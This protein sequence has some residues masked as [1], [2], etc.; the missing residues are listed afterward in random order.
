MLV[1]VQEQW[2]GNPL[3]NVGLMLL[4]KAKHK[5]IHTNA[6]AHT[7]THT[8]TQMQMDKCKKTN[9]GM[10]NAQTQ[11]YTWVAVN[12]TERNTKRERENH[13]NTISVNQ[14]HLQFKKQDVVALELTRLDRTSVTTSYVL[15]SF[16]LIKTEFNFH[17]LHVVQ[18]P[19]DIT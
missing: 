11:I 9:E 19:A 3:R 1:V 17:T 6:S 14:I 15:R 18:G 4:L 2:S 7:H 10:S 16:I 8:C 12:K 13:T 5:N